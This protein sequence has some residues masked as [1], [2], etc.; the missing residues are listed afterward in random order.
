MTYIYQLTLAGLLT[1]QKLFAADAPLAESIRSYL[2]L[3]ESVLSQLE[4]EGGGDAPLI[5]NTIDAL[6]DEAKPVVLAYGAKYTQCSEQLTALVN[7]YP[8]LAQWSAQEIRQNVEVGKA[9]PSA[10]GCYPARDIVAHPAI[11]RVLA[12]EGLDPEKS[13][14]LIEEMR[15]AVEHM[16][17]IGQD[18]VH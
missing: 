3:A 18:L 12:R 6:L 2:V 7:L 4:A 5:V 13:K 16:E 1:S 15:E 14:E 9:L 17:E 11:V 8:S 10:K